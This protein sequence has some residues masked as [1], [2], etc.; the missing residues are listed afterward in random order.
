MKRTFARVAP[1]LI[2]CFLLVGLAAARVR[3]VPPEVLALHP[4]V[5]AQRERVAAA[6]KD[7]NLHHELG[8]IYARLGLDELA[9]QSWK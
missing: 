1:G 5:I 3:D 8:N 2:P 6:P 4:E 7:A 9:A